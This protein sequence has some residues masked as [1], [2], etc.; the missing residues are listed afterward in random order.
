M[1]CALSSHL[2][3]NVKVSSSYII[4]RRNNDVKDFLK[5]ITTFRVYCRYGMA[6]F[7]FFMKR[8]NGCGIEFFVVSLQ[9]PGKEPQWI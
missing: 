4:L 5:K 3:A 1:Q 2:T 6:F 8:L 9:G 7:R